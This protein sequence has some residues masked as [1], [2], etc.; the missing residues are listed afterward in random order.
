MSPTDSPRRSGLDSVSCR[1]LHGGRNTCGQ[2]CNDQ[3]HGVHGTLLP[4]R[5]CQTGASPLRRGAETGFASRTV[6]V[7]PS[8]APESRWSAFRTTSSAQPDR[9]HRRALPT[10]CSRRNDTGWHRTTSDETG[11]HVEPGSV[12]GRSNLRIRCP[13]GRGSSTLPSRTPSDRR[14]FALR[15]ERAS[16]EG[17]LA[18]ACSRQRG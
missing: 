10:A 4:A 3:G 18:H 2:N 13:K 5:D 9:S 6:P 14:I 17:R 11:R 12:P 16:R 8:A 7:N 15:P 1:L